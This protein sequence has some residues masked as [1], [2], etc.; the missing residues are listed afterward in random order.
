MRCAYDTG[1]GCRV[2]G[3]VIS[4]IQHQERLWVIPR[5]AYRGSEKNPTVAERGNSFWDGETHPMCGGGEIPLNNN[6]SRLLKRLP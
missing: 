3:D 2:S 5:S 6:L 1:R 4:F